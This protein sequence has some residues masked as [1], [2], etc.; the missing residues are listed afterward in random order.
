MD[1]SSKLRLAVFNDI[2]AAIDSLSPEDQVSVLG[3][4]NNWF[5]PIVGSVQQ[6][7]MQPPQGG[8]VGSSVGQ[9]QA[10]LEHSFSN[11]PDMSAKLFLMDKS[12]QSNVERIACLAFYLAHYRENPHF[13]SVDISALNTEAAQPKFSN[14]TQTTTDA[15]KQGFLVSAGKANKQL[16]A[17]GEQ[18]VLALPD[19]SSAA[20]VRK[21]MKPKRNSSRSKKSTSKVKKGAS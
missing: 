9:Q 7:S 8:L 14:V 21:K 10:I 12:P 11:Q 20:E 17:M 2:V 4:V 15:V 16:S 19:R 18:Y 13:K 6:V 3:S 5:A 1:K